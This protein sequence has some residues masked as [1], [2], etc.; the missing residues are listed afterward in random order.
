M[1]NL[2]VLEVKM[3]TQHGA[4]DQ[5]LLDKV[6]HRI[7]EVA[8]P[9]K[10]ILFGS[11]ARGEMGPDSDL[12]FLVIVKGPV[13]Q[14]HLEQEIYTRL[15]YV[16]VPVNAIVVTEEAVQRYG[17]VVGTII[18]PALKEGKVVYAA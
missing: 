6:V 9:Q 12:D 5:A 10:V 1:Q 3:E 2:G 4:P 14:V 8:H 16:G 13:H 17:N 15:P 18:R 11:A 7:V